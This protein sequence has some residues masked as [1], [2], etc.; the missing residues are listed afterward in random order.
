MLFFKKKKKKKVLHT[1][2][3]ICFK[4]EIYAVNAFGVYCGK[5][6]ENKMDSQY[7]AAGGY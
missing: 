4:P 5:C 3:S 1:R 2:C 7:D 6:T